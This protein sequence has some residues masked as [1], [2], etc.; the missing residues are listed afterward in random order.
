MLNGEAVSETASSQDSPTSTSPTSPSSSSSAHPSDKTGVIVGGVVGGV[1]LAILGG[2]IAWIWMYHHRPKS[3]SHDDIPQTDWIGQTHPGGEY[4]VSANNRFHEVD[5][6][7]P[8][9]EL[10]LRP[11]AELECRPIVELEHSTIPREREMI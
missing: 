3:E 8:R 4:V 11:R 5:A 10:E 1:V 9:V 2:I 7:W 6:P